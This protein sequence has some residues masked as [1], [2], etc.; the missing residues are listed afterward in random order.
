MEHHSASSSNGVKIGVVGVGGAGGNI[1]RDISEALAGSRLNLLAINTDAG[2][3]QRVPTATLLIGED[4]TNGIGAGADP[5]AGRQAAEAS[6]DRI[7]SALGDLDIVFILSGLGGGTGTG[8]A[9]IVAEIARSSGALCIA[10][11]AMPFR[12]EGEKRMSVAQRGVAELLK[13]ADAVFAQSNEDMISE[14]SGDITLLDGFKRMNQRFVAFIRAVAMLDRAPGVISIDAED[15]REIFERS[16]PLVV[17]EGLGSGPDRAMAAVRAAIDDRGFGSHRLSEARDVIIILRASLDLC[18]GEFAKVLDYVDDRVRNHTS[19]VLGTVIDPALTDEV[20]VTVIATD[21][22]VA[23]PARRAVRPPSSATIDT[24]AHL[25]AGE[26]RPSYGSGKP[27]YLLASDALSHR[28]L[29][30]VV[31]HLSALYRSVGG[32]ELIVT[33]IDHATPLTGPA[34]AVGLKPF[35]RTG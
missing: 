9:P 14:L 6:R 8:A 23:A 27:I 30:E 25:S 20:A 4:A 26:P 33:H 11:A 29:A 13:H 3:L 7:V 35:R 24:P 12:M 21:V 1:L 17:G 22:G 15:L 32:D 18:E 2:A 5:E 19:V 31:A 34:A 16:G 28:Q 10:L